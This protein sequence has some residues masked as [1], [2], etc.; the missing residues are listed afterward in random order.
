MRWIRAHEL[1][2]VRVQRGRAR[3]LSTFRRQPFERAEVLRGRV[4][5]NVPFEPHAGLRALFGEDGG[6]G[7]V[8]ADADAGEEGGEAE[9]A[10]RPGVVVAWVELARA[11]CHCELGAIGGGGERVGGEGIGRVFGE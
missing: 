11:R 4:V 1:E 5:R 10:V 8:R 9:R 3:A 2:R 7:G 6:E